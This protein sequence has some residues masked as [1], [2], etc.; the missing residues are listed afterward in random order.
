MLTL[1][2]AIILFWRGKPVPDSEEAR[3][4]ARFV[5]NR[6]G[7]R[8]GLQDGEFLP[9]RSI[10]YNLQHGYAMKWETDLSWEDAWELTVETGQEQYVLPRFARGLEVLEGREVRIDWNPFDYPLGVDYVKEETDRPAD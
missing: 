3:D 7:E 9:V 6:I 8:A 10:D 1:R 2:F 4:C 5:L